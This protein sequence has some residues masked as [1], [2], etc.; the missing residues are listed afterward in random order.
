MEVN[1]QPAGRSSAPVPSPVLEE[2]CCS[3]HIFLQDILPDREFLVDSG[4]SVSVFPGPKSTSV[5][6]VC[7][8]TADGSLILCSESQI[9]PLHSSCGSRAKVYSWNF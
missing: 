4:A 6:E 7:L 1:V 5:D 9:I 8:L 2:V 3:S